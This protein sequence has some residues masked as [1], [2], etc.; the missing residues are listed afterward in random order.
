MEIL[1]PCGLEGIEKYLSRCKLNL[2]AWPSNYNSKIILRAG[3]GSNYEWAMDSSD[4]D[5]IYC[6][7]ELYDG[8]E[9]AEEAMESLS[10]IFQDMSLPHIILLDDSDGILCK[11]IR[12]DWQ[13]NDYT[14]Y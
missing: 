9:F 10:R 5:T 13:G 7:G 8:Q 1:A 14:K 12:H 2:E 4:T 3:A 6:S 11:E